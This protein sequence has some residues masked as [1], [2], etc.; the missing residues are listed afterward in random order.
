[1]VVKG[2][3]IFDFDDYKTYLEQKI[4]ADGKTRGLRSRLAKKLGCSPAYLTQVLKGPGHVTFEHAAV[5][6]NYFGLTSDEEDYFFLLLQRDRSSRKEL[7][8]STN[9]RI[10]KKL[11]DRLRIQ[12]HIQTEKNL[13]LEQQAIYYSSW[14][15]TATH[16]LISI[17]TFQS[18]S[19]IAAYFKLPEEHIRDVLQFL[20][21]AGLARNEGGRFTYQT[22]RLH[23]GTDSP[24]L[25]RHHSN[26]RLRG[27]MDFDSNSKES[28]H[29]TALWSLSEKDFHRL[30]EMIIQFIKKCEPTLKESKEEVTISMCIDYFK[31]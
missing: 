18:V 27:Q 16:V 1:M 28:L 24:L 11:D 20:C 29:Y 15:Y 8:E 9:R 5:I 4:S 3:S 12:N 6:V 10:K 21:E 25:G 30:R 23:L 2:T 22:K 17:P 7:T 19:E 26:W 13:S 14:I 31:I